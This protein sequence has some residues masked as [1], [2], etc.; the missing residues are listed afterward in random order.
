MQETPGKFNS[1]IQILKCKGDLDICFE[2]N[3][4]VL[5]CIPPEFRVTF[6]IQLLF[7]FV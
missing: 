2:L 7:L 3:Q 6:T 4:Y 1:L 5:F